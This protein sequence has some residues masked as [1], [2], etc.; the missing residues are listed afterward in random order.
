M[1]ISRLA[2][3]YGSTDAGTRMAGSRTE[4]HQI[5]AQTFG[6]QKCRAGTSPERHSGRGKRGSRYGFKMITE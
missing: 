5:W 2:R 3:L 4:S 1:L 6:E